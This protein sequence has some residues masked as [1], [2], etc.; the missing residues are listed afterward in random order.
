MVARRS[1]REM[2]NL[3]GCCMAKKRNTSKDTHATLRERAQ[4]KVHPSQV[5]IR[6]MTADELRRLVYE[7]DLHQVELQ[8][9]NE[10]LQEAQLS[11]SESRDRYSDLYEF[12][13]VGYVTTDINGRIRE[14]NLTAAGML[15][16]DRR[17]L[18]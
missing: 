10:E 9:Q 14:A 18:L 16:L 3:H 15:R 8:M 17:V 6:K 2:E 4:Q 11:L 5:D 12:A 13:P 7:L 1:Q